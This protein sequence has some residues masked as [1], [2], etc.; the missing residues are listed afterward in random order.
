[1]MTRIQRSLDGKFDAVLMSW[2]STIQD[3][4]DYLNTA[5]AT[6]ISNFSKFSDSQFTALMA[7]VNNTNGQSAKARYQEE[8]A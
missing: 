7:K 5:T 2:N 8:L 1:Q 3:P 4:S 6:N